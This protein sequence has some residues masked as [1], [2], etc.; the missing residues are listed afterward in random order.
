MARLTKLVPMA[1]ASTAD[2]IA[3]ACLFLAQAR[4]ITGQVLYV[5]GGLHLT[6]APLPE[7]DDADY[8]PR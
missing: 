3:D 7:K 2:E 8:Y 1:E 6:G 5:D 4:T